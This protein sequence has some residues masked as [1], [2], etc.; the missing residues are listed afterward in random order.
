[1]HITEQNGTWVCILWQ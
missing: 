1:M